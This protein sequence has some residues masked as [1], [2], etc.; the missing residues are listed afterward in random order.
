MDPDTEADDFQ[1]LIIFSLCTDTSV[2]NFLI[3]SVVFSR[4][5]ANRQTDKRCVLRNVHG[6]RNY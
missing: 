2:V 4:R 1:N 3:R 6:G 5:V